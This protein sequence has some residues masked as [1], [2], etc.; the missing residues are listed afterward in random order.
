MIQIKSTIMPVTG[1][2]CTNCASTIE[3]KVRKLP[4]VVDANVDF[5]SEKLSVKFDSNQLAENDIISTVSKIGYGVAT[6]KID[7]PV[8]G[9]QDNNDALSLEKILIKQNGVLKVIVSYGTERVMLEYIPGVTSIAEL[10]AVIRK[11]GFDIVQAGDAEEIEDVEAAVRASELKK[12]KHLLITGLTFTIPLIIYSMAHDFRVVGFRYDQYAMLFAA[13]IVQFIVGWHFYIGAYKSLRYGS[14]NMDVLIAMGSS[15]A[16]FSSLLVTIGIIN[17][18]HVYFETG[19]AIITLIRLGKYLEARAKGKTSEALKALMGLRAKTATIVRDGREIEIDVDEVVVGDIILVRPGGKIPV[20]GIIIE[21][22]SALD[23]SMITGESMPVSKGPG[24]EVI[25][26]TINREGLIRFEAT[27]IGKNTA[28]S[29]IVRLVQEAQSSK[30]PIQKLTDEIGK[31]FVPI[32]IG[33][34]LFT[35]F[36]WLYVAQIDW[37]GAM[38]NAIAVLVIA[39]PCAIG[40]ATPTAIIVG[41]SKGAENGILFKSSEMLERAGKINIVVFD[42][43]GTLTIGEPTV[44]DIIALDGLTANAVLLQAACAERGSEHPLGKALV[45]AALEKGLALINPKQFRAFGGSGIRAIVDDQS[46]VI[47]NPR[48][49]QNEKINI[50]ELQDD[51]QRLQS[52]GKTAMIVAC[53]T[54]NSTEPAKPI[55]IIAVA[56]TVKSGAKEAIYDLRLLGMDIVMITG[57]NQSTAEAIALQVGISNVMAEVLPGDKANAIKK[58]QEK[59]T[60]GNFAPPVVAMVGDGINDAPALAQADV[61][62]A[63]GTG[64][65]IAMA[66]AGIT[67]ISGD[68]SGVG[69]AISLSRGTSQTIVQNLIWAL[70][71]NVALI[72][73]AAYGMLSPMFAAGAMAF[74][75]IFV[76]TNS[77]R[78]K[79]FKVQT[80]APPKSLLRQAVSLIPRIIA[81][82]C[83]LAILIIGPMVFMPGAN[84]E[85]QGANQ[86]TMS[87]LL[88]MVMALSNALIAISYASIPFFLIVFVRK[89]KDMPFTWI[90]FLFGLFIL[91]CGTTHITHVIGLWWEVNWWQATFDAICAVISVATAVVVWPLLPR[92]LSIPSPNQLRMVN[93]E[94]QKEKDKLVFTQ[95][96]LHK[97]YSAVELRVNERTAELLIANKSLQDEATV[98][99]RAEDSLRDREEKFRNVFENSVVGKSL[100]TLDGTIKTNLAFC[101][102]LGYSEEELKQKKWEELTYSADIEIDRKNINSLLSGAIPSI[103]WEKRYI[104]KNGNLVW[105]DISTVLQRDSNGQPL[106]FITVINDITERKKS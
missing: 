43:T 39:C 25:G 37:A 58:L 99:K 87:P 106:Y 32:I 5:A 88:M 17:S 7:L 103:R 40:L 29:Q 13:T 55:G 85:I 72:P 19:A 8:T 101:R 63:I 48:M 68:L 75:S 92:L 105:V 89:R 79:S 18:P 31:Y 46:V 50:Q 45:K 90:I 38:I 11:A 83:A 3:E 60:M 94:L 1:L 66:A 49:M 70:F 98:R 15:A 24:N 10:A 22:H 84:M 61:G 33:I 74:S 100:T 6:G 44:T 91:A 76:I 41:T 20:D 4:G 12:Q 27:R 82:A 86:G 67:L 97:A 95:N 59:G 96:E 26:A 34:A 65:D 73:I 2:T 57:D 64:T 28:L 104:H 16:Y 36:G 53:K 80:I 69:R 21:G 93:E 30:A 102:I 35:F 42:K 23:E 62:I 52:A 77:L 47:G 54:A 14:A 71:Y 9:L 51:I 56:D 78:L 81:P